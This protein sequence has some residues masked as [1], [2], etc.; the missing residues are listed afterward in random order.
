MAGCLNVI[1]S[2]LLLLPR[3][4]G[5]WQNYSYNKITI[6]KPEQKRFIWVLLKEL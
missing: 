1:K 3:L 4:K 6:I 5:I 2:K